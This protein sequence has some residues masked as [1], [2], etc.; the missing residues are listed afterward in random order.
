MTNE[1]WLAEQCSYFE[2][3][4]EYWIQFGEN[5]FISEEGDILARANGENV[6]SDTIIRCNALDTSHKG[7]KAKSLELGLKLELRMSSDTFDRMF[8]LAWYRSKHV[9]HEDDYYKQV[10]RLVDVNECLITESLC[11]YDGHPCSTRVMLPPEILKEGN[12]KYGKNKVLLIAYDGHNLQLYEYEENG[13]V[14]RRLYEQMKAIAVTTYETALKFYDVIE[15][16]QGMRDEYFSFEEVLQIWFDFAETL[17][18]SWTPTSGYRHMVK[19]LNAE[20]K[21]C[22]LEIAN[23]KKEIENLHVRLGDGTEGDD[24]P[25]WISD[26]CISRKRFFGELK[27]LLYH[28]G[29]IDARAIID[30]AKALGLLHEEIKSDKTTSEFLVLK[31]M[32]HLTKSMQ[33]YYQCNPKNDKLEPMMKRLQQFKM[34]E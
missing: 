3:P 8:A 20:L 29:G 2:L 7:F 26:K 4:T 9:N 34:Q 31:E 18:E 17:P 1:E 12:R 14:H 30:S 19:S 32:F 25:D 15:E 28:T 5:V 11:L 10:L 13:V 21:D 27:S 6:T 23:L 24:I 16:Q 33:S 22:R